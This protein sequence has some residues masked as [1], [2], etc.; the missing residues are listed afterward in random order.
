MTSAITPGINSTVLDLV[1]RQTYG[2]APD[3]ASLNFNNLFG[4]LSNVT[5]AS[6]DTG[7]I[8]DLLAGGGPASN[9]SADSTAASSAT[10]NAIGAIA[11]NAMMSVFSPFAPTAMQ[12]VAHTPSTLAALMAIYNANTSPD[13]DGTT[14][15]T[16]T[17]NATN[18]VSEAM[19]SSDEAMAAD[20]AAADAAT[21]DNSVTSSSDTSVDGTPADGDAGDSSGGD[22]GDGGSAGSGTGSGDA[23]GGGTAG[24]FQGGFV[25]GPNEGHDTV[26][27]SLAGG[28]FVVPS[29]IVSMLGRNFFEKLMLTTSPLQEAAEKEAAAK[30]KASA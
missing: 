20:Q 17:A 5:V 4:P 27:A 12:A 14:D 19:N 21:M 8:E 24:F 22:S 1:R 6:G 11:A 9:A 16:P 2:A 26:Q 18:S 25:P 10:G 3:V 28:E 15:S 29:D 13:P 23:G 7:S 30:M